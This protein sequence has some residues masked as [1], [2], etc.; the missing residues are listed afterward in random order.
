M[1]ASITSD[2]PSLMALNSMRAGKYE[3]PS[4]T[5][6]APS[7]LSEKPKYLATPQY[8]NGTVVSA[9]T[10]CMWADVDFCDAP[11]IKTP[12]IRATMRCVE[13]ELAGAFRITPFQSPGLLLPDLCGVYAPCTPV[14][15]DRHTICSDRVPAVDGA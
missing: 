7:E 9:R 4:P 3:G 11:S 8:K 12:H 13:Q 15:A 2:Y 6:A 14:C 10:R 5:S 1:E